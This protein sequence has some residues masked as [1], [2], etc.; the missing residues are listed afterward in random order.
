[1]PSELACSVQEDHLGG[2][3]IVSNNAVISSLKYE[4]IYIEFEDNFISF[5]LVV[6]R[7][8][9]IL[10]VLVKGCRINIIRGAIKCMV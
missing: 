3:L 4:Y 5:G 8:L 9:Y 2:K 1:M 7:G 10:L 6:K